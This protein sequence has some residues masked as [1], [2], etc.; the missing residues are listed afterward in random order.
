[1]S[2]SAIL[3]DEPNLS[4]CIL[5]KLVVRRF[6]ISNEVVTETFPHVAKSSKNQCVFK[7]KSCSP[8]EK[9]DIILT[10]CKTWVSSSDT[11]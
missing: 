10:L 5:T 7:F 8:S 11:V 1:M 3:P 4:K 6:A 9:R 2:P